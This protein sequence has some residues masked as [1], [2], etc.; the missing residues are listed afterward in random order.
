MEERVRKKIELSIP[1]EVTRREALGFLALAI[2]SA[3]E[4]RGNV[5]TYARLNT[6]SGY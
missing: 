5:G 4:E 3:D 6:A 1:N 2:E